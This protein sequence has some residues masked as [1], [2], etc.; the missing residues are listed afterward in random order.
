MLRVNLTQRTSLM[1]PK[2]VVKENIMNI[3]MKATGFTLK[4]YQPGQQ[5][6]LTEEQKCARS[7]FQ[8][9]VVHLE[10]IEVH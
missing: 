8:T 3:E 9:S 4:P 10:L 7:S 1:G 5:C 6:L 2:S